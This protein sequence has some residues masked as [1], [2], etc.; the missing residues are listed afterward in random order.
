MNP[1]G[2]VHIQSI[3]FHP[4][5]SKA[6]SQQKTTSST[7]RIS[8]SL[9]GSK[10]VFKSS[11]FNISSKPTL[12][13]ESLNNNKRFTLPIISELDIAI[14]FLGPLPCLAWLGPRN[15]TGVVREW[16]KDGHTDT[17]TERLEWGELRFLCWSSTNCTATRNLSVFIVHN[18]GGGVG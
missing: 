14:L 12:S 13:C 15:L 7:V 9:N 16:R 11:K 6:H 8:L 17:C 3:A 18:T 1:W 10:A 2:A 4:C 5:P